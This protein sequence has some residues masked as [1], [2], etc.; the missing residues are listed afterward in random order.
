M[1]TE[2]TKLLD[3]LS[4]EWEENLRGYQNTAISRG[5]INT[6]SYAQVVQPLYTDATYRWKNY[7]KHLEKFFP[8][9]EPWVSEFGYEPLT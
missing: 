1:E 3:F 4:L 7:E 8:K 2:I 6:P 9:I 5:R